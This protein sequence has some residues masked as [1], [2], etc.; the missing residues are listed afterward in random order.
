M[1][2][3]TAI[4][5]IGIAIAAA[6]SHPARERWKRFFFEVPDESA[7]ST[8]TAD[9]SADEPRPVQADT[10]P[11]ESK[12]ASVHRPYSSG[13]CKNCH[14][15]GAQMAAADDYMMAACQKCHP[16]FFTDEIEH[17]PVAEGDCTS[18]HLGHRSEYPALLTEAMPGVCTTCHDQE[19]L[20]EDAHEVDNVAQC[21]RCHDPH[22]GESPYLKPEAQDPEDS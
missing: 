11:P 5:C 6:C 4:V 10:A 20:S 2:K 8:D 21:A 7:A 18:C 1:R 9:T 13:L 17:G 12:Y 22:F 16:S 14:D 3:W 15:T 19:D